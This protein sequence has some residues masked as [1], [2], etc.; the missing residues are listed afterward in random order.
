M[1]TR[2]LWSLLASLVVNALLW[3]A[4]SG[5]FVRSSY[6]EAQAPRETVI[7]LRSLRITQRHAP[8]AAPEE[9]AMAR[10]P[11]SLSVPAQWARANIGIGTTDVAMWLDWRKQRSKW[12]PRVALWGMKLQPAYMRHQTLQVAIHDI[13]SALRDDA[14]IQ[15]SKAQRV[16]SGRRAGWFLSY[17]KRGDDPPLHFD[18]ALF[19]VGNEIYRAMYIRAIDEPEDPRMLEA[20][21]TLCR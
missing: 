14:V 21:R 18:E 6:V 15:V 19:L 8:S 5:H 11:A 10:T 4:A 7:V 12:I 9:L 20:L 16:C 2:F 17:L 13:V 1:R 3:V